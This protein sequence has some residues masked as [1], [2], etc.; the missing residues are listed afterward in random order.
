MS[1]LLDIDECA[2]QPCM[3][4][5]S[6]NDLVNGYI[7]D[8]RTG[9]TGVHC[10][11]FTKEVE[12]VLVKAGIPQ[13]ER[14]D[15]IGL[16]T[17]VHTSIP[18]TVADMDVDQKSQLGYAAVDTIKTCVFDRA[19]CMKW[20]IDRKYTTLPHYYIISI[21]A[22]ATD[23]NSNVFWILEHWISDN[24]HAHALHGILY[25]IDKH[26]CTALCS[27]ILYILY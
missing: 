12:E 23:P 10:E 8:C 11:S 25:C 20:V 5:G 6:C 21:N 22:R 24:S 3:N 15:P 4:R 16:A 17:A 2:S 14:H 27:S 7:C 26:S 9:Y 19:Q 1:Y 13:E 18:F